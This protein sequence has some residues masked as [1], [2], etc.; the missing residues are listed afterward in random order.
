MCCVFVCACLS[1][2]EP[3][4]RL[5]P[6]GCWE[7]GEG[8]WALE[9]SP[10][11][12]WVCGGGG[13]PAEQVTHQQLCESSLFWVRASPDF[14]SSITLHLFLSQFTC[15]FSRTFISFIFSCAVS[16]STRFLFSASF[17]ISGAYCVALCFVFFLFAFFFLSFPPVCLVQNY[18]S[19]LS[20]DVCVWDH[21]L[22]QRG[23][24]ASCLCR[25]RRHP[26]N[27][28]SQPS[29]R[30]FHHAHVTCRHCV[31][32]A[33]SQ[34]TRGLLHPNYCATTTTLSTLDGVRV[35]REFLRVETYL[36][37]AQHSLLIYH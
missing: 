14:F 19:W 18:S 27:H 20:V 4:V 11:T 10:S 33:G 25:A 31:T 24:A 12:A 9:T 28:H 30:P 37:A 5:W 23:L 32:A 26:R 3:P 6:A 21:R 1:V 16:F 36:F 2:S 13:H 34:V 35:G 22:L 7:H 29:W 17:L 8:G 15:W